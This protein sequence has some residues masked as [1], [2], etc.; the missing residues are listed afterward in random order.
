MQTRYTPCTLCPR[1][2]GTDRLGGKTGYCG[3]TAALRIAAA[4]IHRGEEPPITGAG[5]SGTIFISGCN[6]GC[7]FCQNYQISQEGMG[8]ALTGEAFAGLCLAL[9]QQQAE[10]INLVT[11][12]HAVPALAAGIHLARSQG[13]ALPVLWNSSAYERLETL[14]LMESALDV[15]LPDLKTLDPVL[16]N[17]FFHASDYPE[18]AE[19]AILW[20]LEKRRLR[21]NAAKSLVS[22]VIIR[23]LVLPDYLESTKAVLHWFAEK[24]Q[25]KALLSVMMQYTPILRNTCKENPGP[26]KLDRYVHTKEYE[27]VLGWFDTFAITEGFYQELVPDT[28]W[29]PDFNRFQPFS[30]ELAHPVWH[31]KEGYGAIADP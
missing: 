31:W 7:G 20:M 24:A 8:K 21:F 22:G 2:C 13:L 17:R 9:Q 1:N 27:Q 29:V 14:A 4:C 26:G 23:H 16:G 25:G 15:Y 28:G 3:E 10:N 12:S 18:H 6:L 19:K 11:G 30:S 5:G